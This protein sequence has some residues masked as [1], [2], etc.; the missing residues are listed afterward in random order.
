LVRFFHPFHPELLEQTRAKNGAHCT[1]A[2][3]PRSDSG[4]LYEARTAFPLFTALGKGLS[5]RG[6][7]LME[8]TRNPEKLPAAKKYVYDRLADGR[9]HPKVAMI[10]PFVQ[11][12][13]AYQYLES[14]AQG[15][16][17]DYCSLGRRGER[18]NATRRPSTQ[19]P[20]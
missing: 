2:S 10:F 3:G 9:F 17:C 15:G 19:S 8:I 20:E 13:E 4:K 16:S 1:C 18:A 6:Y 5:I 7:S 12:L 14:N 11:T